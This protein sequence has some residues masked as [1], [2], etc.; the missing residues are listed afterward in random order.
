MGQT[1]YYK[2]IR[3]YFEFD[4]NEN[5]TQSNLWDTAKA[6]FRREFIAINACI[7]KKK[8]LK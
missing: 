1:R 2:E 7:K 3:K 8:Y 5:T 4:E 6:I